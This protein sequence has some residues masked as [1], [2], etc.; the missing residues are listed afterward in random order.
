MTSSRRQLT[1]TDVLNEFFHIFGRSD[2]YIPRT[3]Q[4]HTHNWRSPDNA[5][6][7]II[8][9][10]LIYPTLGKRKMA[11]YLLSGEWHI[12]QRHHAGPVEL[13]LLGFVKKQ[14][15]TTRYLALYPVIS[16]LRGAASLSGKNVLHKFLQMRP[17]RPCRDF[18][19]SCGSGNH[20]F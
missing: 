2:R 6:Q 14:P 9:N 19:G 4:T 15:A 12:F 11:S 8:A 20:L 5:V 10:G 7:Q 16:F 17:I 18:W 3:D 1:R 13:F